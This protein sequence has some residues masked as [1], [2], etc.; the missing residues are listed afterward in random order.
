MLYALLVS[1]LSRICGFQGTFSM[2]FLPLFQ[3]VLLL[4]SKNS[5]F[6][7]HAWHDT[8]KLVSGTRLLSRTVSSE[9]PSAVRVLTVV[10]GMGTGV[11]P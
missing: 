10:F 3:E 4:A 11:S 7:C 9:V 1:L 8:K 5:L 6:F 2:P